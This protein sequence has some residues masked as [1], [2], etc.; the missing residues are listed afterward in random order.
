MEISQHFL[1]VDILL[2]KLAKIA[3]LA[4]STRFWSQRIEDLKQEAGAV[5][6]RWISACLE[7]CC[8]DHGYEMLLEA[9]Q[10][11]LPVSYDTKFKREIEIVKEEVVNALTGYGIEFKIKNTPWGKAIFPRRTYRFY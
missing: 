4:D 7:A 9:T 1:Y 10:T 2:A 5:H 6:F 11:F 3:C 8:D